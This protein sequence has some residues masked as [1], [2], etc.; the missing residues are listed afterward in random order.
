[1]L[2]LRGT[3]ADPI[4]RPLTS[5]KLFRSLIIGHWAEPGDIAGNDREDRPIISWMVLLLPP[6][7]NSLN[8]PL[9]MMINYTKRR[10][11][12][13]H[14]MANTE[15]LIQCLTSDT[16]IEWCRDGAGHIAIPWKRVRRGGGGC[17]S[18]LHHPNRPWSHLG[19]PSMFSFKSPK[20]NGWGFQNWATS[21]VG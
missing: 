9:S 17:T 5:P 6:S 19:M 12:F 16:L 14:S 11:W 4:W 2:T 1:M 13:C 15:I 3:M 7:I 18:L 21:L 8:G 20:V 10:F